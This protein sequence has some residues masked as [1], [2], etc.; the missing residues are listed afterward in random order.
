M[1]TRETRN[2]PGD[3]AVTAAALAG[4]AR[5]HGVAPADVRPA[6]RQGVAA[7]VRLLGDDL[8]LKVARP[9]DTGFAADLRKEAV[10]IPHAARLGVRTPEVVE[11]DGAGGELG[12]PYLV[13]RRAP[14]VAPPDDEPGPLA[15]RE[16]GEQLAVLHAAPRT[17]LA[18]VPEDRADDPRPGVEALAARGHLGVG[19]A[20]WL[21]G[22]LD[23][24]AAEAPAEPPLV[25]LHGDVSAGNLLVDPA[26]GALTALFD[27]GDAAYA[28][29]AVEFAK[30]PPRAVR[31]V[32]AGYAPDEGAAWWP[33]ILRHHVSWAVGRLSGAP[34]PTATHWSAQ[35][36]NRLLELLRYFS[37]DG[38]ADGWSRSHRLP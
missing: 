30:V 20:G 6:P 28:D 5:R 18:G 33:R 11:F 8:V 26:S 31:S 36:A 37:T 29:P 21:L 1:V 23:E 12:A 3:P 38:A 24:L 22:W 17:P 27:W 14:G 13:L 10:V 7:E 16:L 35:P 34:E 32:L 19:L 4:I 9:G 2:R 25:L 15:Y